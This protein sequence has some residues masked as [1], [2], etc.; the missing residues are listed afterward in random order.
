MS[1]ACKKSE[2][3]ASFYWTKVN[4]RPLDLR[5]KLN[6]SSLHWSPTRANST[7]KI[8][9]KHG[10]LPCIKPDFLP[11]LRTPEVHQVSVSVPLKA[12][13]CSKRLTLMRIYDAQRK[14]VR[15]QHNKTQSDGIVN[16]HS[17]DD[18]GSWT[19][20]PRKL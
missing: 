7:S 15:G 11:R 10:S 1:Y 12:Y 3:R 20:D 13:P 16:L 4:A 17:M 2:A 18:F 8:L 9:I 6:G 5:Q 19:G 14:K